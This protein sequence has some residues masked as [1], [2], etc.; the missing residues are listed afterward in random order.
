MTFN[1]SSFF[2]FFPVIVLLYYLA[3]CAWRC[4]VLL[5]G[6][7][8]FYAA[9]SPALLLYLILASF[10]NYLIGIAMEKVCY[11]DR[12]RWLIAGIVVDLA[13]LAF[14]KYFNFFSI[15]IHSITK[16]NKE[17][18][19]LHLLVPLGISF[20]TF[21]L[22][23]YLVD[24]YRDKISVEKDFIR[25]A[26]YVAFFPKIAQGPIQRADRFLPQLDE[27][28]SFDVVLVTE[29]ILMM[30]Y[31]EFMKMVV[32]DTAGI[33]VDCIFAH[34]DSFLGSTLLLGTILFALQIYCDFAGYSL[35]AIGAARVLGFKIERNFKQPYFSRSVG[36][37]W[38]RWHMSLNTWLQQYV[39]FPL[40]GSRGSDA[41]TT[42][43]VLITFGLS[44]LWHGA[45]W[46]YVIWGILNGVYVSFEN[47]ISSILLKENIDIHN[48]QQGVLQKIFGYILA[49]VSR[50]VTF[51]LV[52]FS[53]IFFRAQTLGA[54]LLIIKRIATQF[55]F[56]KFIRFVKEKVGLGAGTL[57]YDLD[58]VYGWR[59]LIM[60]LLVVFIVDLIAQKIDLP[61]TLA[62]SNQGIRCTIEIALLMAII[63][64]GVYGVGYNSANFIYAGF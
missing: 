2:L 27:K 6:S 43:N 47:L 36:E 60:G 34:R 1:S 30:L 20:I 19:I 42:A 58:V 49:L 56:L 32:A 24:I 44:G 45:D 8:L 37:F 29:G 31:G 53:W 54:S 18:L 35:I 63:V 62:R 23:S 40:G 17:P 28:H 16:A 46:G 25:F 39:Y 55:R 7:W 59:K 57:L 33:A 48:S 11:S 38:R 41:K 12:K 13:V 4:A 3:P 5:L 26:V 51:I 9:Y 21:T 10:V 50:L 61:S 22:I 52:S 15:T 14:Y 64:F